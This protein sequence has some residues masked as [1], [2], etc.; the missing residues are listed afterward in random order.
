MLSERKLILKFVP[1]E[2]KSSHQRY[3]SIG[4]LICLG[5][6][7]NKSDWKYN[8]WKPIGNDL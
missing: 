3:R 8:S 7:R 6:P 1:W 4:L 5:I 2:N